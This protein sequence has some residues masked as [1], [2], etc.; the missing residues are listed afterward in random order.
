MITI[1]NLGI[2]VSLCLSFTAINELRAQGSGDCVRFDGSN[3]YVRIN[4]ISTLNITDTWTIE[5]WLNPD[6][7]PSGWDALISKNVSDRPAS[8]WLYYNSV[9]VW[10]GTGTNGLIAYS[11]YG[12]ITAGEWQ[13]VAA[14]RGSDDTVKIYINGMLEDAR[15]GTSTPPTNSS[16]LQFGRRGD[17]AYYYDGCMDEVRY[18]NV[19]RTQ[20]EI[21]DNMCKKLTGSE[22]GLAHYWRMDDGSGTTATDDA[23]GRNGSLRNGATWNTS[24]APIG[25]DAVMLY[26]SSW[27]GQSLSL[28]SSEGDSV[29]VSSLTGSPDGVILY[30]VDESPNS[31]T[32]IS[33]LGSND[34]YFGVFK[35]NGTSPTYQMEYYYGGNDAFENGGVDDADLVVYERDDNSETSWSSITTSLDLGAQ[36][37]TATGLN[38][39]YILG[40]S[41]G[42][43]L[44]VEL[45][46][47][48]GHLSPYGVDLIW[49]T[50]TETNSDYFM[51]ECSQDMEKWAVLGKVKGQGNSSV[52]SE[53]TLNDPNPH[54]GVN[55]YRLTQLDRDGSA[56]VFPAISVFSQGDDD[57]EPV[58][59]PNPAVSEVKVMLAQPA[60]V[61]MFSVEGQ[62]VGTY[63]MQ[64]GG[65]SIDVSAFQPGVYYLNILEGEQLS[66]TR[67]VV[68]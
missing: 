38:S 33:G 61:E 11:N 47:F 1:R 67:L 42:T 27:T 28:A 35:A 32:G 14:T 68:K 3:D 26:P 29:I 48:D 39:E 6:V 9:E 56:E 53:Y 49:K 30:R 21:R 66:T 19:E 2:I 46:S 52:Q 37:L 65:N 5:F 45:L 36:T 62:R 64:T 20:Q 59:Y 41:G 12:T 15:G 50:A 16:Q 18:W 54:N 23:G 57:P 60:E 8:V 51:V 7:T 58:V 63:A 10:Y 13:H 22:T 55:Y 40:S 25:D 44:P 17:A 4:H 24:G 31:T 43:P 34:H